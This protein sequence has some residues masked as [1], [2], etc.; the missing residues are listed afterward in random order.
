M[1]LTILQTPNLYDGY[2]NV[3]NTQLLYTVSS[4]N[5]PQYQFRYIAD[6]Y[7]N[8]S[9]TRLA[10]FKYPQN[11]SGTANI[12]LSRPIGDYLDTNYS[13]KADIVDISS[14]TS[15]IFTVKFGEEYGTSYSSSVT[16]FTDLASSSL[17]VLKGNIQYPA[18]ED[19]NNTNNTRI[20]AASSINFAGN[21]YT[22]NPSETSTPKFCDQTLSNNPNMLCQPGTTKRMPEQT[23]SITAGAYPKEL[24]N[25]SSLKGFY[26]AQPIGNDDY[27]TQT[28]IDTTPFNNTGVTVYFSLF[29]DNNNLIWES[30][31][32]SEGNVVA[33]YNPVVDNL[34]QEPPGTLAVGV[35]LPNLAQCVNNTDLQPTL[36]AGPLSNHISSS[37]Q[38]NWY[39]IGVYA[40]NNRNTWAANWYYNEDKGPDTLL[41]FTSGVGSSTNGAFTE[42]ALPIRPGMWANKYYP[43]YCNNEKTRFA[44]INSFGVWDYYNVY[45]PTRRST[46]IDRKTYEQDR[47][48]LNDRIATYNVSNRGEKQYY[49]EYTDEFEITTDIIDSQES[50]WL[51]E[52]FESSEVFIQSGS[53]FI[54]IN[55]LNNRETIINTAARNK[56]YQYTI[57]YQ[58]SNLREPR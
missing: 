24:Y 7:Y 46:N 22:V 32:C 29:D 11:S 17:Q 42:F 5:V 26:V 16:S 49:T 27:A 48:N 10:R 53:D 25:N 55:I 44:F 30:N 33:N 54:P 34:N 31:T 14:E 39:Q 2:F 37:A 12:D 6:L 18:L 1:A 3:S 8:G 45:M 21:A 15:N 50:Q 38:W 35:G 58:F 19:Y 9:A 56:N 57:R 13:W 23:F 40:D 51:R 4:S 52:M 20:N 28:Y 41:N 43:T 36:G 47:I